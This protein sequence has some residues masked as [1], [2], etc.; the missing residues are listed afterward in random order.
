VSRPCGAPMPN[1][2]EWDATRREL[3]QLAWAV[4]LIDGIAI[5]LGAVAA[6]HV[7]P[8]ARTIGLLLAAFVTVVLC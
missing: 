6:L 8:F 2:D 5:G 4:G 3:A 7:G 1:V